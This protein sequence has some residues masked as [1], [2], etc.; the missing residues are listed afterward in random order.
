MIGRCYRWRGAVWR[1]VARGKP[2]D[3]GP[4]RNVLLERVEPCLAHDDAPIAW[5]CQGTGWRAVG[6]R[7]VRPFR[8]L[9]RA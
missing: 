9:R 3:R 8:G 6:E 1:V 4:R 7:V 2:F 5:C